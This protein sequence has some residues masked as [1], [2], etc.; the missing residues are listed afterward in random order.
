[1]SQKSSILRTLTAAVFFLGCCSVAQAQ[2]T[3]T[4][5]SGVGDDAN[6]CSRTAPCKTFA[7]AISKTA[8]GGEISVL[9]PGGYGAV[10]ITKSITINGEG[11]LAGILSANT[12][13]VIVNTAAT[14]TVVLRN[15]SIHG[16]NTGLNGIRFIG[17]GALHVEKLTITGVVQK[18]ITFEPV[19]AAQLF[20]SDTIIRNALN[21]TN[22]GA[23]LVKPGPAGSALVEFDN[24]R[25]EQ[26][27]FGIRVED[28]TTATL[29]NTTATGNLN[30]GF[31]SISAGAA[32][33]LNLENCSASGNRNA[34][35]TSSGIQSNGAASTV[36]IS[37]TSVFGNNIGLNSQNSGV[38]SSFINNRIGGNGTNNAPTVTTVQQ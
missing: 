17:S 6:P 37:N 19:G 38:I 33:T 13:G 15:I 32:V 25:M 16:A 24:V 26:S 20:V 4:W 8:A 14:D 11:T 21:A 23:V 5:V 1:M 29:R 27:L 3:R 34:S 31:L 18:G 30:N 28:R 9:D 35:N 10:T 12:N 22:G 7:G 36:R 2:A